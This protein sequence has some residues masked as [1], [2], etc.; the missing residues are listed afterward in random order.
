[1]L[2]TP[3]GELVAIGLLCPECGDRICTVIDLTRPDGSVF[4]IAHGSPCYVGYQC[5]KCKTVFHVHMEI[6]PNLPVPG[7]YMPAGRPIVL[8]KEP[9]G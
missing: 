3:S 7:S 2:K 1:M 4:F 8:D 5:T 6:R 9:N